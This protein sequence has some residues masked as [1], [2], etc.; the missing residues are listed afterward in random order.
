MRA[1]PAQWGSPRASAGPAFISSCFSPV[2]LKLAPS[3]N[4]WTCFG[5][6]LP[7]NIKSVNQFDPHAAVKCSNK[8]EKKSPDSYFFSPQGINVFV[9]A[10]L[11]KCILYSC[12]YLIIFSHLTRDYARLRMVCVFQVSP[13]TENVNF[14]LVKLRVSHSFDSAN[15]NS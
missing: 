8:I 10:S 2:I 4:H 9:F 13:R 11:N 5:R 3:R 1:V 12:W 14:S 6:D 15:I 7:S